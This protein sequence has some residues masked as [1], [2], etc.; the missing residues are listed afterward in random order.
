MGARTEIP[1]HKPRLCPYGARGAGR[2][3]RFGVCLYAPRGEKSV[4]GGT[5]N[6]SV[7]P[8]LHRKFVREVRSEFSWTAAFA[9]GRSTCKVANFFFGTF[10]FLGKK[11]VHCHPAKG[12]CAQRGVRWKNTSSASQAKFCKQ[13]SLGTF[14]HWRRQEGRFAPED[15]E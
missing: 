6:S 11:K 14:S 15:G 12:D 2:V 7:A 9:E 13:K 4:I 8:H 10:F 5:C 1:T 3:M